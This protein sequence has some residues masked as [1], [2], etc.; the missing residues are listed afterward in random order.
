MPDRYLPTLYD[1][2]PKV[3]LN[4]RFLKNRSPASYS[5]EVFIWYEVA[6]ALCIM[7]PGAS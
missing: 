4:F 1:A 7:N 5:D 6:T 3:F 2:V